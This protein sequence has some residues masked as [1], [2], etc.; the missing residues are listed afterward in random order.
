MK[1][2]Y[3]F[4]II[5]IIIGILMFFVPHHI[6]HVCP[7][8]ADGSFMKCHWMAE[9]VRMLGGLVVFMGIFFA[10]FETFA[11]GIALSA[12]FI[13]ICQILLQFVV[14]GT[15]KTPTMSCNIYT[16]PTIILLSAILIITSFVYIY[17]TR[18]EK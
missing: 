14:I 4:A 10:L 8:K 12:M 9:A 18:K 11:K 1:K 6:A 5:I 17:L 15:C 16:K 7:P 2:R 3:I 13:G